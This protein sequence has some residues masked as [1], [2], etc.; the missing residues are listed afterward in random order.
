[1]DPDSQLGS[2]LNENNFAK[3]FGALANRG[4]LCFAE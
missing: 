3:L 2:M 4:A 1:M